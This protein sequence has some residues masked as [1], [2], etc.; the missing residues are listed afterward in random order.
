MDYRTLAF[1][2][3]MAEVFRKNLKPQQAFARFSSV[4]DSIIIESMNSEGIIKKMRVAVDEKGNFIYFGMSQEGAD[5]SYL[6]GV[7]GF[8]ELTW[9]EI[10]NREK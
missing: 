4:K 7:Y 3:Q 5:L 10:T 1:N 6:L 2:T 9:K 8:K